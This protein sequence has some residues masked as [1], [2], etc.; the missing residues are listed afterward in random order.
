[1]HITGRNHRFGIIKATQHE[2]TLVIERFKDAFDH[3][4][5]RQEIERMVRRAEEES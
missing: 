2:T 1:M 5:Y 3:A 4:L